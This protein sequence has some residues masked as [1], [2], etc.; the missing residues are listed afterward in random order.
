ME[1]KRP[2]GR[3]LTGT[4]RLLRKHVFLSAQ[5]VEWLKTQPGGMGATI[6]RLVAQAM[7]FK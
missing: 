6:R 7:A 2:A 4:E 5:M 1:N 3:P